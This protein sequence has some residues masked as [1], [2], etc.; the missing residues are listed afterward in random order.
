[1]GCTEWEKSAPSSGEMSGRA[2][3]SID[4]ERLMALFDANEVASGTVEPPMIGGAGGGL[5]E[6][7]AGDSVGYFAGGYGT[8]AE[9]RKYLEEGGIMAG[10]ARRRRRSTRRRKQRGGKR[11][12]STRGKKPAFR[13]NLRAQIRLRHG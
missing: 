6:S 8:L 13:L 2:G 3:R 5:T 9:Q 12:A 1:M 4:R 11:R 7:H 10:G